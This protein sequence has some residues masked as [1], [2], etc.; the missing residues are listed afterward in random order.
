MSNFD[1][2]KEAIE[3][4]QSLAGDAY[5]AADSAEDYAR[6]ASG[7]AS[8]VSD[9]LETALEELGSYQPFDNEE[10]ERLVEI[11]FALVELIGVNA[12]RMNRLI[13]GDGFSYDEGRFLRNLHYMLIKLYTRGK[14]D[15]F[16]FSNDITSLEIEYLDSGDYGKAFKLFVDKKEET[17]VQA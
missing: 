16:V 6:D 10:M 3:H 14:D 15:Q 8:R 9:A 13:E 1:T 4:A 11:Q 12:R 5:S 17:N 7:Y 2:V